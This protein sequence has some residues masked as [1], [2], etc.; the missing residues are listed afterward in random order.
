MS[1]KNRNKGTRQMSDID[2]TNTTEQTSIDTAAQG[3]TTPEAIL[4]SLTG[5]TP[6]G[7]EQ[8]ET[9]EPD[10]GTIGEAGS[11]EAAAGQDGT[12]TTET[13]DKPNETDGTSSEGTD[14]PVEEA[15]S[16]AE[17]APAPEPTPA[18]EPVVA[19]APQPAPVAAAPVN[20]LG[21]DKLQQL[22]YDVIVDAL[23]TYT[24]IMSRSISNAAGHRQ[25]MLAFNNVVTRVLQTPAT[26][27][28]D[29]MFDFFNE[30]ANDLMSEHKALRGIEHVLDRDRVRVEVFYSL[31][32][33]VTSRHDNRKIE[34]K[35]AADVLKSELV[36]AYIDSKLG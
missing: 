17:T 11:Q 3:T 15:K 36:I 13:N 12:D 30:H 24:E 6:A 31:F 25:A 22:N 21:L 18:P 35:R 8:D 9:G 1:K 19:E 33:R 16:E 28:L 5:G 7:T 20:A 10:T 29:L 32:R 34:L 23:K 27:I 2:N 4:A 14:T 26:P